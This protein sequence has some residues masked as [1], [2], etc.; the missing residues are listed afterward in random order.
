MTPLFRTV[1][2]VVLAVA[3]LA[4]ASVACSTSEDAVAPSRTPVRATGDDAGTTGSSGGTS[5]GDPGLADGGC[6]DAA[7]APPSATKQFLNQCN[8]G[9]C[10]PFDNAQRIEGFTAGGALPPLN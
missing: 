9:G 8:A 4:S 5:S 3:P 7:S 10:F 6:F 1:L 2:V